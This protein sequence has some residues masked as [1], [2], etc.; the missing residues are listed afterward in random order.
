[1]GGDGDDELDGDLGDDVLVGGAGDD[2]LV[3]GE[4]NDTYYFESGWGK[5]T[6]R[7]ANPLV[8]GAGLDR[9]H[10]AEGILATDIVVGSTAFDLTMTHGASG[11]RITL[12]GFFSQIAEGGDRGVDEVRFT[13]GTTW[14]VD[15]LILGQQLGTSAA[16]YIHGRT[17]ADTIDAGGGNDQ[18][19]GYGGDDILDGG[20]GN[21]RLDG[22]SGSDTY[23]FQLGWGQDVVVASGP[24]AGATD[25]DVISFG[26]GV[27]A[28]HIG[29]VSNV[30]DLTLQHVNGDRITL[31]RFF[32]DPGAI[33]EVRFDDGTTWTVADLYAQQ[34]LGN[35]ADQYQYG[36]A[37]ADQ[38]QGLGGN[39]L[40][41][42]RGGADVLE[43]GDGDDVLDGG[44]G[45]D[46]LNGGDGNDMFVFSAGFG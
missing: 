32:T 31:E 1:M 24:A 18:V 10:F 5:D 33:Q 7:N 14:S 46:V 2:V 11:D 35:D 4:G 3:G 28:N 17:G 42:G 30:A 13:D 22:G 8:D 40:V 45:N 34:M 37:Q 19:F 6:I 29:L 44:A 21:D 9:I 20:A 41:Y 23:H 16:Q 43:G 25:V 27:A 39:D 36:T 12:G 15:D 38:I 26:A